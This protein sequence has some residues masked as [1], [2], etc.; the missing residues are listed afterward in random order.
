[1]G[2]GSAGSKGWEEEGAGEGGAAGG[3]RS[4]RDSRILSTRALLHSRDS[5][6]EM[7]ECARMG[8][9]EAG[10]EPDDVGAGDSPLVLLDHV[11]DPGEW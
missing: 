11:A 3:G 2:R 5:A 4:P 10:Y 1:M 7:G 6:Q 8:Y 9:A